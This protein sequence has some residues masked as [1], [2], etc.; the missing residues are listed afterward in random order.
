MIVL[1]VY[2]LYDP[3]LH[4]GE[5]GDVP[6]GQILLMYRIQNILDVAWFAIQ[7]KHMGWVVPYTWKSPKS[8]SEYTLCTPFGIHILQRRVRQRFVARKARQLFHRQA[9]GKWVH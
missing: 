8:G 9:T 5:P 6:E 4:G 1:A 7:Q 3:V 2:E